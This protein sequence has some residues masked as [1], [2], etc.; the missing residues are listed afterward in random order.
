M[1]KLLQVASVKKIWLPACILNHAFEKIH[2]IWGE[3]DE[4]IAVEVARQQVMLLNGK[5]T[6]DSIERAGHLVQMERPFTFNKS[7]KIFLNSLDEVNI[8]Q[9]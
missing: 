3:N 8:P 9:K 4:I 7:L 6:L 5:A 1:K 2:F